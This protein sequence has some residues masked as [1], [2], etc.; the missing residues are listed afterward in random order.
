[1]N[2]VELSK[3]KIGDRLRKD[4]GDIES[5]KKSIIKNGLFHPIVIDENYNLIAG[6]R[7]L[8]AFKELNK[9]VPNTTGFGLIPYTMINIENALD[10]EL[11]ENTI[12]KDFT[13]SEI[14]E[15]IDEVSETRIGHKQSDQ[16]VKDG[17]LPTFGK[18]TTREIVSKLTGYSSRQIDKI[19]TINEKA[20]VN[21]K[22][23]KYMEDIDNKKK[24]V[25]T[26]HTLVTKESRNLPKI[27]LPKEV[28][29]VIYSDVPVGH[30]DQGG[31]F[32]AEKQYPIM[33]PQDLIKDFK[34]LNT[35][36]NAI[37]FFFMSPSIA[38]DTIPITYQNKEKAKLTIQ[39]PI[40]KA[41][42]DAGGFKVVKG[43]F[44]WDKEIIGG[45]SYNRNQH[46]NL[47][48][49]IKGNFPVPLKLYSSIIKARRG[50]HSEKPNE[51]I[52]EML[53]NMYP[54]R[55]YCQIYGRNLRA[56]WIT[57]GNE[58]EK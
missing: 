55:N 2:T 50:K 42:L 43:E 12:R 27:P 28:C 26:V 54:K 56:G 34:T 25:N 13:V 45:G 5:L 6:F 57:H 37:C 47:F 16:D 58:I 39:V 38:Y 44:A 30:D 46:E 17:K 52:Q 31:R 53:E 18:G 29:D 49:A 22:F 40:Y 19:K 41:I 15:I 20:K 32:A 48:I 1:M 10:V 51:L 7:R 8:S 21:K 4:L 33:T 11:E 24:S 35:P 36:E 23:Q 9:E 14:A 3:I